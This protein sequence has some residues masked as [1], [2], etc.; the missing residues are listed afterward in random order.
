MRTLI[1]SLESDSKRST[2]ESSSTS[3]SSR[4]VECSSLI[5]ANPLCFLL[6]LF[7]QASHRES[8]VAGREWGW[9]ASPGLEGGQVAVLP[10]YARSDCIILLYRGGHITQMSYLLQLSLRTST[11]APSTLLF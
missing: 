1:S 7:S 10:L 2:L 11:K 5:C 4:I 6:K 9:V 8:F 3:S